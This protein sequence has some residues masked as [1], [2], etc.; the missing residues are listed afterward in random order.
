MIRSSGFSLMAL[1]LFQ[2]VSRTL[3]PQKDSKRFSQETEGKL[4]KPFFAKFCIKFLSFIAFI[5]L[6]S[7][8]NMHSKRW[9][10][11]TTATWFHYIK[12]QL[13][14]NCHQFIQQF[15][16]YRGRSL[17]EALHPNVQ[18][19]E[20]LSIFWG[21]W[22][23]PVYLQMG[24]YAHVLRTWYDKIQEFIRTGYDQ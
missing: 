17:V 13:T 21:H 4:K 19:L 22:I 2:V 9:W 18:P 14:Q 7:A 24:P 5:Q 8:R 23:C 16:F 15:I 20:E 6:F 10:K 11:Y 3:G 1:S 12:N